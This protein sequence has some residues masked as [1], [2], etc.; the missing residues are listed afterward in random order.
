MNISAIFL[1][2]LFAGGLSCLAVQGG[3][4]ATSIAQQN[5]DE[6]TENADKTGHYLPVLSF[7]FTRLL[8]YSILG[9]LLGALGSLVQLSVT[10]SMLLQFTVAI[11]MIG[12][13]LNLL[14]VHPIFR[15]FVI[16]PPRFLTRI[17]RNQS[18]SQSVFGPALLGL[19]TVFIPCGATQ[20][21]MAYAISTGS[22]TAGAVTMFMFILGTSPLFFV[23]GYMA[24][25]LGQS[26]KTLFHPVAAVAII[27]VA[28]YNLNGAI[29]LTGSRYTFQG[30]L[31]AISCTIS[32]CDTNSNSKPAN[33]VVS[34][35]ASIIFHTNGY[36]LAPSN[37]ALK[38][39]S[40]VKLKLINEDGDGCIQA[41]TIPKL[42]I[43]KIVRI[44]TSEELEI[45]I[46]D[47]TDRLA[48]TCS[49]GMYSGAIPVL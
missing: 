17:V 47:N 18:K 5:N 34:E 13:A 38:K 14:Q 25:R 37:I 22:P 16:S 29:A 6:L 3:L 20:A 24:K 49:M 32:F 40:D 30:V 4:L 42:N 26:F 11:F 45:R 7:L 41:F 12:T 23:L 19:F 21:M 31:S 27:I 39:G 46:P 8:A 1:T 15:Y 28:L 35:E 48:F 43:K 33:T 36:E 44:G 10:T 9:T 2:G